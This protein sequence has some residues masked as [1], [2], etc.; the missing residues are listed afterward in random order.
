MSNLF[1]SIYSGEGGVKFMKN[2]KGGGGSRYK[3]LVAS[4]LYSLVKSN[5][6]WE[7]PPQAA[8]KHTIGIK[9][10]GFI[11]TQALGKSESKGSVLLL[12]LTEKLRGKAAHVNE[13]HWHYG[14]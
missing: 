5:M 10:G 13:L 1:T 7:V 2:F 11:C 12:E 8:H 14:R 3:S 6:T 4:A 9:L